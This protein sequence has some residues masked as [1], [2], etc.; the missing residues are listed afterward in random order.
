[1]FNLISKRNEKFKIFSY[2]IIAVTK[3]L[4]YTCFKFPVLHFTVHFF[5][6][7]ILLFIYWF[8]LVSIKN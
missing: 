4:G 3:I 6:S 5:K 2:R 7:T 1:M 8:N